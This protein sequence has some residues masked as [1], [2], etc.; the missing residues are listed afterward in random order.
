MPL[1]SEPIGLGIRQASNN[2]YLYVIV[3][4]ALM[5]IVAA[6]SAIFLR[7]WKIG[8][9]EMLAA[10]RGETVGQV[11]AA[12]THAIGLDRVTSKELRAK[13]S[14]IVKRLFAWTRV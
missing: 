5:Y 4:T 1:V 13:R 9:L 12:Q 10:E 3:Y 8:E 7:V 2:E 6:I 14:S 11:D